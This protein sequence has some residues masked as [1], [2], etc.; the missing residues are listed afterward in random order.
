MRRINRHFPVYSR[1]LKLY[2]ADYRRRF[3]QEMLETAADM[4]AA[5]KT[6]AERLKLWAKLSLDLPLSIGQQQLQYLGGV[7]RSETP[8][9][10]KLNSLIAGALLLPFFTALALNGLDKLFGNH[11]L[12]N[13]W[14]WQTPTLSIWVLR[15]PE[16]AL[17]LALGSYLVYVCQGRDRHFWRTRILDLKHLWPLILSGG[18]AFGI[19]FIVAFHD[20]GQCWAHSPAYL[21]GHLQQA[22]SCSVSQSALHSR[23][24]LW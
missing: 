4:Q 13:S 18:L 7:M 12:Q 19:L 17:L 3:E 24:F 15:L 23:I 14:L 21:S 22:W 5:A 8:Q 2:P 9:Y 10:I 6:P 16:I 20:S 1:L 11:S